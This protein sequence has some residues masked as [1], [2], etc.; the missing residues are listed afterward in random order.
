MRGSALA[1]DDRMPPNIE[2]LLGVRDKDVEEVS[3]SSLKKASLRSPRT[4]INS[5]RGTSKAFVQRVRFFDT[6]VSTGAEDSIAC[7]RSK[8]ALA[9]A[10][11]KLMIR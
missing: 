9:Y 7:K 1:A 11:K 10:Y 2:A 3:C 5:D 4:E 6:T 8:S